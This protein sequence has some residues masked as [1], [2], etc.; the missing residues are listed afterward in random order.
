[1]SDFRLG[2]DF[3]LLEKDRF[4]SFRFLECSKLS[5]TTLFHNLCLGLIQIKKRRIGTFTLALKAN[6]K[7]SSASRN[8]IFYS[9]FITI[10][11]SPTVKARALQA[12]P[13]T[14]WCKWGDH[15]ELPNLKNPS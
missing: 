9:Y 2:H 12:G 5:R 15:T 3:P 7:F 10:K 1:M 8:F 13:Y 11:P 14:V 4:H 6:C